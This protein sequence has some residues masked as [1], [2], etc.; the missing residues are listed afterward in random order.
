[1]RSLGLQAP[2]RR[3]SFFAYAQKTKR[4]T[5]PL[6]NGSVNLGNGNICYVSMNHFETAAAT[7]QKKGIAQKRNPP[8]HQK[9]DRTTPRP[10]WRMRGRRSNSETSYSRLGA[11][12]G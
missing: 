8:A 3:I 1:V 10:K 12:G 5:G 2:G 6:Q 9:G 7:E 11:Q 4:F